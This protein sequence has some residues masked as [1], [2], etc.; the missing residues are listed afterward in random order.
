MDKQLIFLNNPSQMINKE[1][2]NKIICEINKLSIS[3]TMKQFL[4]IA[5]IN[6]LSPTKNTKSLIYQLDS[7]KKQKKV[8][9]PKSK[10]KYINITITTLN[11]LSQA[12]FDSTINSLISFL[13]NNPFTIK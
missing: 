1:T 2:N 11:N 8:Y 10:N 5:S 3:K 6:L 4:F 12:D 9:S 13:N 7:F